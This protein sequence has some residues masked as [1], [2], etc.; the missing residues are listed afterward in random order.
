MKFRGYS[1]TFNTKVEAEKFRNFMNQQAADKKYSA[2]VNLRYR[3]L[4]KTKRTVIEE[5]FKR[6]A[7]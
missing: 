5:Y 3:I 1:K 6:K 7:F 4:G 2:P